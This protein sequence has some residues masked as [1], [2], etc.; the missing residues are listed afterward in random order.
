M[1]EREEREG[2]KEKAPRREP[3]EGVAPG[4]RQDAIKPARPPVPAAADDE[5]EPDDRPRRPRPR[6]GGRRN[7]EGVSTIIPYHNGL[8]LAGYYLGVFSLVPVLG[9]ILGPLGVIFGIIGLRKVSANPEIKGT[10]HAITAIVL[11]GIGALYNWGFV[12]V[13]M[14]GYFASRR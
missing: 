13:M 14:V 5:D 11:G 1:A 8:A 9:L 3:R 6:P 10:G 4:P 2:F 12:V 7:D